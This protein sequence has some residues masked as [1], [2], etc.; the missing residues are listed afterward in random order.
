MGDENSPRKFLYLLMLSNNNIWGTKC[1]CGE[2]CFVL[3]SDLH[4]WQKTNYKLEIICP[5]CG[6]ANLVDQNKASTF[7]SRKI[8]SLFDKLKP[9]VI[10]FGCGGGFLTA[11]AAQQFQVV[12]VYAVDIDKNVKSHVQAISPKVRFIEGSISEMCLVM[13]EKP[14]DELISR[15]VLMFLDNIES[16]IDDVTPYV[17]SKMRLL[18]WYMPNDRRVKNNLTPLQIRDLFINKGWKTKLSYL[19]WYKFGYF[20]EVDR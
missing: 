3:R 6:K 4:P 10:D 7:Y 1:S 18:N 16:F 8:L 12:D 17:G 20:L 5:K 19:T 2:D 9:K 13:R 11:F 14:V 15:D